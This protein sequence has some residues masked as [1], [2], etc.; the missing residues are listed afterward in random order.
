MGIKVYRDDDD[1]ARPT[2][3]PSSHA[4][5]GRV[6]VCACLQWFHIS[7]SS[8]T[9]CPLMGSRN[10]RRDVPCACVSCVSEY[11]YR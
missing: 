9:I 8:C 5:R 3:S 7:G 11:I 2:I 1:D 10:E 4:Q 6:R